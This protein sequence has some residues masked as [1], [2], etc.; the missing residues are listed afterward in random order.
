MIDPRDLRRVIVDEWRDRAL[1]VRLMLRL[2]ELAK[3]KRED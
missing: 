1:F 2:D 3:E